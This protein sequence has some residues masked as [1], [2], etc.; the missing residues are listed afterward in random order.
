MI[1]YDRRR[2]GTISAATHRYRAAMH[3][4]DKLRV[5]QVAEDLAMLVYDYTGQFPREERFGLA[6][7]MRRAAI[8]IGSNIFE[9]AGRQTKRA[10]LASL[11]IA[12]GE[13]S[14]LLFQLRIATRRSMG[15]DKMARQ[16]RLDLEQMRVKLMRLIKRI[17]ANE[18]EREAARPS[19]AK[20]A[21]VSER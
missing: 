20:R 19:R 4:P 8:S 21:A 15:D 1:W 2:F 11:Y 16:L 10:F 12:F 7:Q 18:A 6:S 14:E 17:E 9:G 3:N 5:A 13:A